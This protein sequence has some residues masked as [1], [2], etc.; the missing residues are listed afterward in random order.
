MTDAEHVRTALWHYAIGRN[1]VCPPIAGLAGDTGLT[2]G[3]IR[4]A[5][6]QLVED[7]VLEFTGKRRGKTAVYRFLT[8]SHDPQRAAGVNTIPRR[9]SVFDDDLADATV[10]VD[11]TPDPVVEEENTEE[12][13]RLGL[14]ALHAILDRIGRK[15]EQDEQDELGEPDQPGGE[16]GE[17]RQEVR[18]RYS[19]GLFLLCRDCRV[20]R[21]R[22]GAQLAERPQRRPD[23]HE[24]YVPP[25]EPAPAILVPLTAAVWQ[26]NGNGNGRSPL[27]DEPD[28]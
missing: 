26:H 1:R 3:R 6:A 2:E 24:E 13:R 12:L 23:E 10:E 27:W 8:T 11:G 5:L 25:A 4:R 9:G 22:A 21:A 7:G 15:D 20:R 28:F 18:R 19:L 17:C 14:T 16:C